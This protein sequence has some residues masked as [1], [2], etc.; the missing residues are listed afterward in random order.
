LERQPR[1]KYTYRGK[2]TP[3]ARRVERLNG[4]AVRWYRSLEDEASKAR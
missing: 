4:K 2:P 3:F 1:R